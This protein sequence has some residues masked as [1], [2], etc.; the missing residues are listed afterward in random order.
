MD[1]FFC[2]YPPFCPTSVICAFSTSS[3]CRASIILSLC[4]W[5]VFK[6]RWALKHNQCLFLLKNAPCCCTPSGFVSISLSWLKVWTLA[7]LLPKTIKTLQGHALL[8]T[9]AILEGKDWSHTH[10]CT[11]TEHKKWM[12]VIECGIILKCMSASLCWTGCLLCLVWM[13]YFS[14][15]NRSDPE[16]IICTPRVCIWVT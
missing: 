10:T 11:C 6:F 13:C 2:H 5:E 7:F 8:D 1:V 3:L 4:A 15:F 12:A 14:E 9:E 16:M